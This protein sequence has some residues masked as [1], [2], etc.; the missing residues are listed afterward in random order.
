MIEVLKFLLAFIE[1]LKWMIFIDLIMDILNYRGIFAYELKRFISPLMNR[2]RFIV[3]IGNM[4]F[5]L[6]YIL[7]IFVLQLLRRFIIYLM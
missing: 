4:K 2:L 1:V 7:A 5:N 3:G 6:T